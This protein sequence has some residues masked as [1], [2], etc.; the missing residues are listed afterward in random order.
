MSRYLN[1]FAAGDGFVIAEP[2]RL[3]CYTTDGKFLRSAPNNLF[4]RFPRLFLSE[5]EFLCVPEGRGPS[6]NERSKIVRVN[7]ASDETTPFTEF[8]PPPAGPSRA[9]RRSSSAA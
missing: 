2:E 3:G 7:P 6:S 4:M 9:G 1:C 5:R 8:T